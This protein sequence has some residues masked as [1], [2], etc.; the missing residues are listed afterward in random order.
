[1]VELREAVDVAALAGIPANSVGA[2]RDSHRHR[3]RRADPANAVRKAGP[4]RGPTLLQWRRRTCLRT[5]SAEV[6]REQVRASRRP[7]AAGVRRRPSQLRRGRPPL[8]GAG[9]RARSRSARAR[10]R[11]VGVL[12]PNGATWV[13]AM[14]AAARIGAV[15]VPFSTFATAPEMATQ[16]AHAD[17]EI[18]LATASYRGH[19]YRKRL[20]DI[21]EAAVPLLRHVLI[22]SEPADTVDDGTAGGDGRRRR[23]L[24][25]H[26]RSCTRRV[27]RA[28]RRESCTPMRRCSNISRSSTRSAG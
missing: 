10:A 26:W 27:P 28:P 23:R 16:L 13:V 9:P 12:Y 20:A 1:M 21:D 6:L 15:V 11:H 3:D 14:L 25:I 2:L 18:L 19:D 5:P 17:V 8:G 24:A 7:S 22:D 4:R